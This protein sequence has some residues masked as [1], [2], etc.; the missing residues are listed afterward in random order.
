VF[1][2]LTTLSLSLFISSFAFCYGQTPDRLADYDQAKQLVLENSVYT[3]PSDCLKGLS[4]V[5]VTVVVSDDTHTY[6]EE[7]I[8]TALE[9]RLRSYGIRVVD[10]GNAPNLCLQ[11]FSVRTGYGLVT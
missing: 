7:A 1:L 3:R 2:K 10:P 4:T 5:Y 8:K 6:T 9:L 11:I